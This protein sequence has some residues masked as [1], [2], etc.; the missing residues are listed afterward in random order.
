MREDGN[1]ENEKG[2]L[3]GYIH[4]LNRTISALMVSRIKWVG[5]LGAGKKT[6]QWFSQAPEVVGYFILNGAIQ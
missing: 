3:S 2:H 1:R 6:T 4:F 5:G